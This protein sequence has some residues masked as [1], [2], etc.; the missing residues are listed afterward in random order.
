MSNTAARRLV[1]ELSVRG[2]TVY[3]LHDFDKSGFSILHTLRTDTR[4]YR[5]KTTPKVID[6]GLTLADVQAMDLQSEPYS[7]R[8]TADP[9]IDLARCG[10][11]PEEQAFLVGQRRHNPS[12]DKTYWAG[13]RVELNAMTSDQ[14]VDWLHRRLTEQGVEKVIPTPDILAKTYQLAKRTKAFNAELERLQE[15]LQQEPIAIPDDLPARVSDTL[16]ESPELSWDA[17]VWKIVEE[18]RT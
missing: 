11:T 16:R 17:A 10:A 8:Q 3:V 9:K 15:T 13:Q 14:F 1:D 5:F 6:L 12:T 18:D 7:Y 2:V 4:R